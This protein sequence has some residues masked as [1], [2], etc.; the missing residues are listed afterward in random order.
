MEKIKKNTTWILIY[1]LV[2][3]LIGFILTKIYIQYFGSD[4]YGIVSSITNYLSIITLVE[5]GIGNNI[6]TAFYKPL[7]LNDKNQLSSVYVAGKSILSL[8]AWIFFIW[9]VLVG[10]YFGFFVRTGYTPIW[11]IVLVFCIGLAALSEY[12]YGAINRLLLT[13]DQ[14]R[15]IIASLQ[16]FLRIAQLLVVIVLIK[17]SFGIHII[18]LSISIITVLLYLTIY[19][20]VKKNYQI[21]YHTKVDYNVVPQKRAGAF[22]NI[23]RYVLLNTDVVLLTIFSSMSEV[24]VYSVYIM[25]IVAVDGVIEVGVSGIKDTLGK[26]YQSNYATFC[27]LFY[28]FE[29][30]MNFIIVS[31]FSCMAVLLPEFITIYIK[32]IKDGNYN[33]PELAFYLVIAHMFYQCMKIYLMPVQI[34]GH[35]KDT[36]IHA[37]I[38]AGLNIIIS[39]LLVKRM[40]GVG[41]AIGTLIAMAYRYFVTSLYCY[42]II[43]KAGWSSVLKRILVL[44]SICKGIHSLYKI[45]PMDAYSFNEFIFKAIIFVGLSLIFASIIYGLIYYKELKQLFCREK[46]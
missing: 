10:T 25:V 8:V 24:A 38:E 18:R 15:Y 22:H 9:I 30:L 7:A 45:F 11:S 13:A 5:G 37:I 6:I 20:Y 42:N 23:A 3:V 17:L 1:Q 34:V 39:M 46:I 26:V 2:N 14:K 32:G 12:S 36:Q 28:H 35:Y 33:R 29:S 41:L 19:C 40:G 27:R 16:T 31:F 44:G 21:D 43:L 4:I